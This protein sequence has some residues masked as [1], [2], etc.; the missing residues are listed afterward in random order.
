MLCRY[1]LLMKPII[2]IGPI[3]AGKST[4]SK[5]IAEEL[6]LPSFSLDAE[7]H[8]ATS[9]GYDVKRY[10]QM[11]EE[12]GLLDAYEYRRSFYDRLV[13]LFLASHDHGVLDLG[14]GHP[15]VPDRIKQETIKRVLEPY[16][17]IVLLMPTSNSAES[18]KILRKRNQLADDEPDLNELYFHNGNRTFWEIAKFPVYTEG[19]TPEQTHAEILK[20]L[21]LY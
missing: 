13:P 10:E 17:N 6:S 2:F 1:I 3:G 19:K 11:Q 21:K 16:E 8:L 4:L 18:I 5:M 20:L 9:V 15:I 7:E 12:Q 14:G